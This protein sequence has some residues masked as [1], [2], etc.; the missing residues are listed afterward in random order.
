MITWLLIAGATALAFVNSWWLIAV[1]I[2]SLYKGFRWWFYRSRPW[3]RVHYPAMRAYAAVAGIEAAVAENEGRD[4]DVRNALILLLGKIRP[5]WDQERSSSLVDREIERARS[6]QDEPLIRKA[7]RKNM[8]ASD[9]EIEI[10]MNKIVKSIDPN[11]SSWIVRTVIAGL[12]EDRF[13]E[14]DRG[15][16]LME[17]ISGNAK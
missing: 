4:F 16:Y 7:I 3:R 11:D 2:L 12:I 1:A 10:L 14:E 13:S 9:G 15:E 17:C 6:L 8:T 5:D